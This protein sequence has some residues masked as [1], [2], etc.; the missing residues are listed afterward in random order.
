MKLGMVSMKY[1]LRS[2][3]RHTR[4]TALSMIGVGVGC[5]MA[6]LAM[7]YMTG[8]LEMQIRAIAESGA[9]HLRIVHAEWPETQENTLRLEDWRVLVEAVKQLPSLEVYTC[10]ARASGLLAFGNRTAAAQVTA[11]MP[12]SEYASNRVIR[13]GKMAGRYLKETDKNAVVIGKTLARRLDVKLD[14]DLY[15]TLSGKEDIYSAMFRI[16]GILD[17]GSSDLDLNICHTPLAN[18]GAVTGMPGPGE[19]SILLDDATSIPAAQAQLKSE[20]SGNTTLITWREIFPAFAAGADGDVAF[21]RMMTG[22]VVFVVALGIMSAQLTAVLER[23]K[24]FAMLVALGM[25]HGQII[26]MV[27][28]EALVVGL[29][30]A[31]IAL[32]IGGAGAWYLAEKGINFGALVGDDLGFGGILMDPYL[33]GSFGPWLIGHALAIALLT[34]ILATVY[35]AWRATR[36]MPADALRT[37]G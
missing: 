7:S 24:E 3:K 22:I 16:V 4:R 32:G 28:M 11:V 6:L 33:Y 5:S 18:F 29:G 9:G 35:P 10:R 26:L 20:L 13:R 8:A 23:R 12:E 34:T 1:A 25:K 37:T 17:T 27:M 31:V 36:I 21:M 19:I 2:L 14:D 30:G 15:A